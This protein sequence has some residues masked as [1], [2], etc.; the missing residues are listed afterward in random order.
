MDI[1]LGLFYENLELVELLWI[2]VV[3][4]ISIT[5][6]LQRLNIFGFLAFQ[7]VITQRL[8]ILLINVIDQFVL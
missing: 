1:L 5:W 2:R 8:R 6:L 7:R 4:H 3:F